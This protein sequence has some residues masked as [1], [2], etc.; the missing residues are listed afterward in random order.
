MVKKRLL[1]LFLKIAV[2]AALVAY[3]VREMAPEWEESKQIIADLF[4]G[5]FGY[6]VGGVFC[7]AVVVFLGTYRWRLLL[8]AHMVR[9]PFL[10]VLKLF[11]VG[12]FF[13]Q[14]MPGGIAGGDIVKS[15]YISAHTEDRK[16]EAVTTI[17]IDRMT[18]LFGL[19]GQ[20][21]AHPDVG[22]TRR[23]ERGRRCQGTA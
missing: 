15:Y 7:F 23:C 1:I 10:V 11:F 16:H 19:S 2:G 21:I 3:I 22:G 9:L 18:G 14:F 8:K 13:S 4:K 5:R 6:F 17:F 20:Q 12:H